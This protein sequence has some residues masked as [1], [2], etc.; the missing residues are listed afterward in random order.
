MKT[1]LGNDEELFNEL[2]N[3]FE[4]VRNKKVKTATEEKFM[5]Q[6]CGNFAEDEKVSFEE[7]HYSKLDEID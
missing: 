6:F 2:K 1:R 3:K 5:E 7:K 4:Y